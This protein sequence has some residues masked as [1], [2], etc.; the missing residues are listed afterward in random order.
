MFGIKSI[1]E[2]LFADVGYV[3]DGMMIDGIFS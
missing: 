2:S 1:V 3:Y